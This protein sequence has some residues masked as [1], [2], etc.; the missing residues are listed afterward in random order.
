MKS[1]SFTRPERKNPPNRV[2]VTILAIPAAVLW[3][4]KAWFWV[5]FNKPIKF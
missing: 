4:M 1:R 3:V 5:F 2:L